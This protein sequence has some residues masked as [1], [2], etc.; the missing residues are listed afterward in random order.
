MTATLSALYVYPVKS[1]RGIALANAQLTERGLLHD[2]EWMIVAANA[3]PAPFVTQR[4]I[5]RL[6]LIELGLSTTALLFNAPG[7]PESALRGCP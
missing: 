1:C 7:M 3:N 6:A 5:P 2:R 4:E